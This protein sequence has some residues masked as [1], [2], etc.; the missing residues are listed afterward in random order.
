MNSS[1]V[2]VVIVTHNNAKTIESCVA[3]VKKQGIRDVVIVDNRSTDS[4]TAKIKELGV[5]VIMNDANKG[6]AHAVNQGVAHTSHD[7]VILLNPDAI[8]VGPIETA[9]K[10]FKP[11]KVGVVGLSMHNKQGEPEQRAFGSKPTLLRLASR[12]LFTKTP[13]KLGWVSAGACLINKNVFWAVGGFDDGFFLY[14]E[15]VDFCT[16]VI[17]AGYEVTRATACK[18]EH[19]KG[20]SMSDRKIKAQIFDKSADR[21][22]YK[23]YPYYIWLF[24]HIFRHFYRLIWPYSQ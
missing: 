7:I 3:S 8:L 6:F 24:Q 18:V 1:L 11:S 23:H 20:H 9:L 19:L 16:R 5:P 12:K 15:D 4:T 22:F 13:G 21:Y 14:W 10:I 2:T 17:S